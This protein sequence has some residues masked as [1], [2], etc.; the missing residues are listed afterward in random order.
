MATKVTDSML[1]EGVAIPPGAVMSFAVSAAP[2]GWL[3][4]DGTAVSRNQYSSLFTAVGTIYGIGNN[5]TTFNVPNLQGQF[6]RGLTT[7]L[8]TASRDPLSGS[9]VLGSVQDD[10]L[11]THTH[12]YNPSSGSGGNFA[13]GAGQAAV[14]SNPSQTGNPSTG[15]SSE[16]RPVNVALLYCIKY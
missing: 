3:A 16:T 4:C 7:N 13:S 1:K 11:K 10:A 5:S 12:E 8:S 14:A 2:V 15:V 9:R 6:I